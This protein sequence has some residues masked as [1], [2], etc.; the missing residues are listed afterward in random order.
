M[1]EREE[2]VEKFLRCVFIT[3]CA[4]IYSKQK[5]K[6]L[7]FVEAQ[8]CHMQVQS[9]L[10]KGKLLYEPRAKP[11]YMQMCRIEKGLYSQSCYITLI[12][13]CVFVTRSFYHAIHAKLSSS[14][15]SGAY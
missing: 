2:R 12:K 6:L 1:W 10:E 3:I 4:C 9:S 14:H 8:K 5:K 7:V 13:P 11:N 15:M